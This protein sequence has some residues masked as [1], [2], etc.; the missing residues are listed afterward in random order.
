M[1]RMRLV[2][3]VLSLCCVIA[4]AESALGATPLTSERVAT[5]LVR[6]VFTTAPPGD[7]DRLFIIEQRSGSTGRIRILNLNTGLV[8]ATLESLG[9]TIPSEFDSRSRLSATNPRSSKWSIQSAL[10][11]RSTSA[12]ASAVIC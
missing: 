4:A 11:E 2:A 7:T 8:N 9:T 10:A 5:G 3:I 12:S 6:P 1:K